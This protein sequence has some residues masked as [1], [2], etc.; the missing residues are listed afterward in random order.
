MRKGPPHPPP[1]P[2]WAQGVTHLKSCNEALSGRKGAV[3]L[4]SCNPGLCLQQVTPRGNTAC[5]E[6]LQVDFELAGSDPAGSAAGQAVHRE[7]HGVGSIQEMARLAQVERD[8]IPK[9]LEP[10]KRK[11]RVGFHW[12][13]VFGEI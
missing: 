10:A 2:S 6:D 12:D 8:Q 11:G 3:T 4:A 7:Q 9:L 13:E 1:I 5:P